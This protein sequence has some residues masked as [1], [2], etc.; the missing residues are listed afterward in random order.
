MSTEERDN[1]TLI[2]R[3]EYDIAFDKQHNYPLDRIDWRY[4]YG[5]AITV[6]EAELFV[7][8]L[9]SSVK[10]DVQ[11]IIDRFGSDIQVNKIQEEALEL[12]LALNQVNCPTKNKS[13]KLENVYEE[14]ADMKIMMA[15]AEKLFDADKINKL[16]DFK[17][18]RF[19]EK[20]LN[21]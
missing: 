11:K 20:Y 16:V 19:A 12:A 3:L 2:E 4:E 8:L 9:K 10:F 13:E 15:Q 14:L 21:T 18:N 17:L 5:V 1:L 7:N 6:N